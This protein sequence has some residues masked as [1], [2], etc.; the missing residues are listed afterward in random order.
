MMLMCC[1]ELV[2]RQEEN[3]RPLSRD[4]LVLSWLSLSGSSGENEGARFMMTLL[5]YH[6]YP[7]EGKE[8]EIQAGNLLH[9]LMMH[10][11]I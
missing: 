3:I 11:Y 6:V 4:T 5:I 7:E 8:Q 2:Y 1:T 9:G 10:L